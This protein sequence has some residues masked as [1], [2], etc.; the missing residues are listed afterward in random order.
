MLLW[1]SVTKQA[2]QR[3]TF[4]HSAVCEETE[5]GNPLLWEGIFF[6][7]LSLFCAPHFLLQWIFKLSVYVKD[8]AANCSI[9]LLQAICWAGFF[10]VSTATDRLHIV[11]WKKGAKQS[12]I[13]ALTSCPN[14]SLSVHKQ[15]Y[16]GCGFPPDKNN[17]THERC[18]DV[19]EG[20]CQSLLHKH[21]PPLVWRSCLDPNA[22]LSEVC[23]CSSTWCVSLIASRPWRDDVLTSWKK[24]LLIF[25]MG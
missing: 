6:F 2:T 5:D 19:C 7:S 9:N 14:M 1:W 15:V 22:V 25:L 23:V 20:H 4:P 13:W 3:R 10:S 11:H 17:H 18:S 24:L 16:L 12:S 8:W 21:F